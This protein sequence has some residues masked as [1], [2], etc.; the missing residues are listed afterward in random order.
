MMSVESAPLEELLFS[1]LEVALARK[2]PKERAEILRDWLELLERR[3]EGPVSIRARSRQADAEAA[4][5]VLLARVRRL[6]AP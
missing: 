1:F 4:H 3:A 6:M 5:R 2:R